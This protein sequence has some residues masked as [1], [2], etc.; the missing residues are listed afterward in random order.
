MCLT[1]MRQGA[2]SLT[3]MSLGILRCGS[4]GAYTSPATQEFVE[5]VR[6][7]ELLAAIAYARQHLSRWAES[8]EAEH[9]RACALLAFRCERCMHRSW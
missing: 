2:L 5:L 6:A 4:E 3:R 1:R 7:E 8:Y 9:Q